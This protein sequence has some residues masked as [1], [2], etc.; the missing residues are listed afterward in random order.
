MA[1]REVVIIISDAESSVSQMRSY[2]KHIVIQLRA[3]TDLIL[4]VW[5]LVLCLLLGGTCRSGGYHSNGKTMENFLYGSRSP[6]T[7]VY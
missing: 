1:R 4:G 6:R 3:R 2:H 5:E 7:R